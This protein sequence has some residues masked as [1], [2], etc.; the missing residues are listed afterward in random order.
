M[1]AEKWDI[2]RDDME[3]FA[4]E[5]HERALRARAEGRFDARDRAAR[6][7]STTTKARASPNLD[8]IR[9]LPHAR[10]GRPAH[11]RGVVADLR[12]VGRAADRERAARS[13][14]TA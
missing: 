9:S 4:V 2:T 3:A 10:R 14:R 1:I 11:R 6:R 7:A 13:R 12:R 8:K 5:S